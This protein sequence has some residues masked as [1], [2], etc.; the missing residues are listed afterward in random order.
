MAKEKEAADVVES[1]KTEIK[2]IKEVQIKKEK[3]IETEKTKASEQKTE[4]VGDKKEIKEIRSEK[5][6]VEKTTDAKIKEK[7]KTSKKP[8]AKQK[9]KDIVLT[10]GK[11]KTAVARARIKA[12]KGS[13]TVNAVPLELVQPE[14]IRLRIQE[15]LILIGDE[16][17][18]FD[19]KVNVRGGGITG[20]ADAARLAIAK[21]LVEMLGEEAKKIFLSYDRNLLVYDPRRAEQHK[22]PHSSWGGRR[23]KQ[24]SKR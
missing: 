16:W 22:P 21:G 15:P 3:N 2:E 10:T 5:E 18:K 1:Q 24:R 4:K 12:G 7:S 9:K 19:I 17:K 23:Y 20:Q 11:R 6:K 14:M 8:V 13:V